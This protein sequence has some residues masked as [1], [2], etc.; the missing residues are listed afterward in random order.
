MTTEQNSIFDSNSSVTPTTPAG[1]NPANVVQPNAVDTMLQNIKNERGEPKYKTLE[2]A[3][4][5]LKHSQEYIPQLSQ[6]I[7]E[8]DSELEAARQAASKVAQLE[9]VVRNLTQASTPSANTTPQGMTAEQVA[10][11]VNSTLSR[12]QQEEVATSNTNKVAQIVASKF[13]AEAESKFYGK[14][15]ELGMSKSEFNTLAAKNPKAVL[16]LLGISD[17]VVAPQQVKPSNSG[18]AL[19]TAGIQPQTDTFVTRNTSPTL[20]GATTRQLHEESA[21]A[22]AMVDELHS[23]GKEIRDLTDPKVYFKLFQ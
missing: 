8:K 1:S 2:D 20:V 11:L 10:E 22:R 21:K 17:T 19:N 15:E 14:A 12:K 5:A 9:D 18:T 13:G 23:Q 3:L 6:K 16:S 4:N 7:A